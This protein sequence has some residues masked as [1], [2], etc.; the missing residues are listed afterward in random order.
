MDRRL[1][2]DPVFLC[3]WLWPHAH[4]YDKQREILWAAKT[5]RETYVAAGNM[6]GKDWILGRLCLAFWVSPW[7]FFGPEKFADVEGRDEMRALAMLRGCSVKDLPE[8]VVHQRRVVTT[9]V[10]AEHLKVLW[11]EIGNAW[12]T[13]S[14]DLGAKYVMNDMEVRFREEKEAAGNAYSYMSG[15]VS[16]SDNMEGL[17]GHH[18]PYSLGA[19]DEAS[20]LSNLVQQAFSTWALIMVWIGNPKPCANFFKDNFQKGDLLASDAIGGR[21]A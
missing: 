8:Y 3:Q 5:S 15:K 7:T 9:S 1:L 6:L 21:A 17:T 2:H 16:G 13:C 18:A 12:R 19:G 14:Q 11:G 10:K 4:I 20:G